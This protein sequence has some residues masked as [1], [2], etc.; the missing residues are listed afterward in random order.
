LDQNGNAYL[1]GTF[2]E[3]IGF[4]PNAR[5]MPT[6]GLKDA[7]LAKFSL[8]AS[9]FQWATKASSSGNDRGYD[10]VVDNAGNI[11]MTGTH[12]G[13]LIELGVGS[14]K[15]EDNVFMGKW[16]ASGQILIGRNGFNVGEVDYPGGVAI[17]QSGNILVAGSFA[18][19]GEF[20]FGSTKLETA[21]STDLIISEIDAVKCDPTGGFL[22]SGGGVGEE[23]A[24]RLC[25]SPDGFVYS[26]GYFSGT[27]TFNGTKL[28]SSSS[29]P[30]TYIVKY[31][32]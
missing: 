22:V 31:R 21:G 3:S 12:Q 13:Y 17:T 1:T 25:V 28:T 4:L 27:A 10:V 16:N 18:G 15:G 11:F 29:L 7:F 6:R 26:T 30:N 20:P 2:E 8:D 14:D 9:E 19:T 23:R 5:P 32:R 24:A